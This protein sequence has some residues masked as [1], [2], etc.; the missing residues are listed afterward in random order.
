MTSASEGPFPGDDVIPTPD[1]TMDRVLRLD[2]SPIVVWP[3]LEQL[4]RQRAGWYLPPLVERVVP[5]SRRAARTV[6]PQWLGLSV[7]DEIPDWG[8]G[9]PTFS[10]VA[11]E[12]PR[13]LVYWSTRPRRHRRGQRNPPIRLTWALLLRERGTSSTSLHLR[14]RIDLGH[15][16]GPVATCGGGFIDWLTVELLGRGLNDRLR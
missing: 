15:P 10:V 5:R 3:W 14:L 6:D 9:D 8:P 4:G 2:A 7:G 11:I 13:H 12:P 1:L 16:A